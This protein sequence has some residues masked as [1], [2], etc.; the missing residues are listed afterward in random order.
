MTPVQI[1]IAVMFAAGSVAGGTVGA[2]QW[3]DNRYVAQ[4]K[5]ADLL[6]SQLKGQLRE[7]RKA[8][9]ADPDNQGIKDEIEAVLDRLCR[10][11]AEDRDCQK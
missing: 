6:W 7:L 8:L 9:A 4:E 3:A 5:F 1:A 11:Y 10:N 2:V